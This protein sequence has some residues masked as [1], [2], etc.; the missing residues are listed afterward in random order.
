MAADMVI[1]LE[2]PW[3]GTEVLPDLLDPWRRLERGSP[4][5]AQVLH[6]CL[7]TSPDQGI[8]RLAQ[9]LSERHHEAMGQRQREVLK[10]LLA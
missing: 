2:K 1:S 7:F 10:Y 6:E 8:K 3:Q 4:K 5:L 9:Y